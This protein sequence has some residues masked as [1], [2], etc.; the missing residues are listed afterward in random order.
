[1]ATI[2]EMLA[3][4]DIFNGLPG[5]WLVRIGELSHI[6]D[7]EDRDYLFIEGEEPTNVF[8]IQKGRIDMDV[9]LSPTPGLGHQVTVD[10][11]GKGQTCGWSSVIGS[12]V[13]TMSA[14][15]A[16]PVRVIAINGSEL[17]HFLDDNPS[18]GFKVLANMAPI[19]NSR[20][21]NM[22]IRLPIALGRKMR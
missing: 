19:V 14:R 7:Y 17:R 12:H 21:R 16:E 13:Y 5:E 3:E 1:M 4:S 9:S 8:I 10:T 15:C 6:E 18:I 22:K 11:L 2:K 20:L